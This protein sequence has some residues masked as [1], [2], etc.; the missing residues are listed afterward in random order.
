MSKPLKIVIAC[1][2]FSPNIN[3]AARFAERLAG[4]LV[5]HGHEVH[6]IVG[7]YDET[8]GP[9]L[10]EHDGVQMMVHRLQS[11]KLPQ[12]KSQRMT[13]PFG[14][15]GKIR[16]ILR[17]IQ[18]DAIHIQSHLVVGRY[19]L[20]A[21]RGMSAQL[22]ATNHVMPENLLKYAK[23]PKVLHPIATAIFWWDS[24]RQLKKVST[25]TT[26]T[27]RAAD[28]LEGSARI[29]DVLAISC[30]IDASRFANQTPTQNQEP[31][32]LFLGRLDDEKRIN[33]LLQAVAQLQDH[34]KLRVELVGDGSEREN[35]VAQAAGLGLVDRVSFLGHVRDDELA[36]IYERCTVFVMPSIAE[37]Q[38]IATME[39]M[40]SGRPV[41][42]ADAMALPHLVHDGD[43]GYLFEPD[44]ATD[45]AA[46][47]RL[48]L[49]ADALELARLS[50][51]SLHLIQSHDIERTLKIFEDLYSGVGERKPTTMDNE[52]SYLLPIGRLPESV[53]V[54]LQA[55]R[56]EAVALRRR[57]EGIRDEARGRFDDARD[58]FG[59]VRAEVREQLNEIKTEVTQ[60]ARR[61][62]RKKDQ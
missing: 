50:E 56:S 55:W 9:R 39:A 30:G 41:I 26:P 14:M 51:N 33:I 49:E 43:N 37:L 19:T 25:V 28:L 36:G 58:R 45:L 15:T 23:L 8:V 62:R 4:G 34:P 53:R 31:L 29:K 21:A 48:I 1:D 18:P 5:R 61:L 12:H 20:R 16:D 10:E 13:N 2:T 59:E 22:L 60:A 7:S 27:R 35:L 32:A 11:I 24:G 52:A 46:K 17:E 42:G 44:N 54:R 3:G 47:L 57:A 38:S 40:A 6:I